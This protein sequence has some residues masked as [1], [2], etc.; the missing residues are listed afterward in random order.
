[1]CSELLRRQFYKCTELTVPDLFSQDYGDDRFVARINFTYDHSSRLML[2]DLAK[3]SR[4]CEL[5]YDNLAEVLSA[6]QSQTG[7]LCP[8]SGTR[9]DAT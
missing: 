9:S 8:S 2:K 4:T 7:N 6:S 3:P 1:V 5:L